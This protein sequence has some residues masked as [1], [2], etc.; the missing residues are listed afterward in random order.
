MRSRAWNQ[1]LPPIQGGRAAAIY[2]SEGRKSTEMPDRSIL[3]KKARAVM[4]LFGKRGRSAFVD[5][6]DT[7]FCELRAKAVEVQTELSLAEPLA[8][9]LF[10][11]DALLA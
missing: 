6:L 3:G 8:R 7:Q 2:A 4:G 9:L 5:E 1:H 10:L 11:G